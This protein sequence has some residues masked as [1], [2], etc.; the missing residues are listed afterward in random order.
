MRTRKS[1]TGF[2]FVRNR[3]HWDSTT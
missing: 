2:H 3:N 1:L